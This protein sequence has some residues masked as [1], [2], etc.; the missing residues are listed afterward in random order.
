MGMSVEINS[1]EDM[2]MLMCDNVIPAHEKYHS[3]CLRCGRKLKT[4]EAKMRGYG[5]I[6]EKK[7]QSESVFAL[8]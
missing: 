3:R 2:C 4:E 6:C 8:L 7:I 1:L 5:K